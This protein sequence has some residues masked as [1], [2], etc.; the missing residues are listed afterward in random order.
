MLLKVS[1]FQRK[2]FINKKVKELCRNLSL[3][4]ARKNFQLFW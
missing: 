3:C 2:K 4:T 1:K